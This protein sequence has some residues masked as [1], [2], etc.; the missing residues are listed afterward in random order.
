VTRRAK[1]LVPKGGPGV[2]AGRE[3]PDRLIRS[4]TSPRPWL[5]PIGGPGYG[6]EWLIV[7]DPCAGP[8]T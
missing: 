6:C 7:P 1:A 5:N 8:R 4:G 2:V 3:F